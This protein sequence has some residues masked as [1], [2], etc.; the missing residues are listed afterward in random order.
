[1]KDS[2]PMI[3]IR[4]GGAWSRL[5]IDE[6]WSYRDVLAML[7]LRD[8]KLRYKQTAL[9]VVWVLLQPLLA[10]GVFSLIFGRFAGMPSG[11]KPYLLFVFTGLLYWNLFAGILQRSGGSIV[12]E[13]R[14]ITKVYFPRVFVP[15]AAAIS[16]VVDF[17]VSLIVVVALMIYYGV[18]PGM[19]VLLFPVAVG[20]VLAL[21][22]G[23]GLWISALNVRYRD[24]SYVL[25]FLI[26]VWMYGS[27]VVYSLELV[28]Q[29]WALLFHLNPMVGVLECGRAAAMGGTGVSALSIAVALVCT[30]VILVSGL[31]FFKRVERGFADEL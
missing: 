9:G 13:S 21:G 8:I 25:P 2:L 3:R 6:L 4:V 18:W 7:A 27:P 11:G 1:M 10:G 29:E 14:L 22:V 16:A 24:F 17:F 12:A 28:P 26:Q 31:Y 23:I 30:F 19:W 15:C 20:V 5:R